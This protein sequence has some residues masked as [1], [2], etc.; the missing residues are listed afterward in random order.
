VLGE[1]NDDNTPCFVRAVPHRA[2]RFSR[3]WPSGGRALG[4]RGPV[5]GPVCPGC[6]VCGNRCPSGRA[7][8]LPSVISRLD[9][10]SWRRAVVASLGFRC[11]VSWSSAA[12]ADGA[13]GRP[14]RPHGP[15]GS[16]DT[17]SGWGRS[18]SRS[19]AGLVNVCLTR[20]GH[21][22]HGTP[23]GPGRTRPRGPGRLA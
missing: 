23:V 21:T 22:G 1:R 9:R 12:G 11:T 16:R 14:C 18:D 5:A 20:F 2:H 10:C 13:A 8:P 6:P 17:G 7:D 3:A 19:S 15:R 4:R